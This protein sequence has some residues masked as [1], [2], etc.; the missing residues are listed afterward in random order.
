MERAALGE[1]HKA[2]KLADHLFSVTYPL[3]HDTKLLLVILSSIHRA[4]QACL[5]ALLDASVERKKV[6]VLPREY[7]D[8]LHWLQREYGTVG[9]EQEMILHLLD[10]NQLLELHKKCPIE[11]VRKDRF[12]LC[13]DSY[14]VRTISGKEIKE[15][16]LKTKLFMEKVTTLL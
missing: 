12:V 2:I 13:T 6:T 10:I 14:S 15:Y 1:A 9:L 8:R 7:T 16:L 5:G 11:F 3:A 4:Q